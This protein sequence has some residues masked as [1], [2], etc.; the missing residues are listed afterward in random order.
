MINKSYSN[1]LVTVTFRPDKI[2]HIHYLVSEMTLDNSKEILRFT[3]SH[4]PWSISPIF[5]TGQDFMTQDNE[6]RDF[7][8]SNEVMQYCSA[9]AFVSDSVAKRLLANFFISMN[10]NKIPMKFLSTQKECLDWLAT[11]KTISLNG[12]TL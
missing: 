9:M 7:N 11:F 4:S 3:R 6:S 5:L 8:G 12:E 2:T 10:R 1:K